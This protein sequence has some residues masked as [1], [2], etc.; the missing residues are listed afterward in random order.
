MNRGFF[1]ALTEHRHSSAYRAVG[2]AL[3]IRAKEDDPVCWPSVTTLCRDASV[4]R[5]TVARAI[6]LFESEGLLRV[7]RRPGKVNRYKLT[8]KPQRR[9]TRP[10]QRRDQFIPETGHPATTETGQSS[11][12]LTPQRRDPAT[13]ETRKVTNTACLG[14]KKEVASVPDSEVPW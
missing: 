13:T 11:G 6:K 1:N 4:C 5:L 2:L 9:V 14:Q 7:E 10:S 3:A 12:S 8:S